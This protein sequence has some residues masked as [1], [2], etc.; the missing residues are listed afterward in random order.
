[1]KRRQSSDV[2]N[3]ERTLGAIN[4]GTP[5]FEKVEFTGKLSTSNLTIRFHYYH[6]NQ[7]DQQAIGT[8][9]G[10]KV[11]KLQSF[12]DKI[13]GNK[14]DSK[15]TSRPHNEVNNI[16]RNLGFKGNIGSRQRFIWN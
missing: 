8:Y 2:I 7:Y 3:I 6:N 9:E 1:M 5:S 15:W 13:M 11:P 4:E 16:L 12:T 14:Q 10:M